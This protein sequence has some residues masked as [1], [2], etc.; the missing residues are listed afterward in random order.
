M[1]RRRRRVAKQR[2]AGVRTRRPFRDMLV[3][4]VRIWI[5]LNAPSSEREE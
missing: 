5:A 1:K 4:V 3:H 2:R